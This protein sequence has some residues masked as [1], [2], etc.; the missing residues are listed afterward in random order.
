MDTPGGYVKLAA[1]RASMPLSA[2]SEQRHD[3]LYP[4]GNEPC[5]RERRWMSLATLSAFSSLR[6]FRG[7]T[8]RLFCVPG[9]VRLRYFG[10]PRW[11]IWRRVALVPVRTGAADNR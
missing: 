9:T 7:S 8:E 2:Y 6:L 3:A 10:V 5:A 4:W 11:E 1:V